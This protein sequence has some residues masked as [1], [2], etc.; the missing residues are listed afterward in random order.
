MSYS[1]DVPKKDYSVLVQIRIISSME[2]F[3]S[4][5]TTKSFDYVDE[6]KG[7]IIGC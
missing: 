6:L 1:T 4:T 2:N 7:W 5:L 3:S